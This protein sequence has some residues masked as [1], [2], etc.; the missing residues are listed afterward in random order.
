MEVGALDNHLLWHYLLSQR[1]DPFL[2][3]LLV[4]TYERD[5][6]HACE[7]HLLP[8]SRHHFQAHQLGLDDVRAHHWDTLVLLAYFLLC[9]DVASPDL[10]FLDAD[11]RSLDWLKQRLGLSV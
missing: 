6:H 5:L 2:D 3:L 10:L 4:L 11:S 1:H 7:H 8:R 9:G